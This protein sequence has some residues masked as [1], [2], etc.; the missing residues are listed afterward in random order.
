[1][2][3]FA[4]LLLSAG[5]IFFAGREG[6][7]R[8]RARIDGRSLEGRAAAGKSH[9]AGAWTL[10]RARPVRTARV[11][12]PT[13]SDIEGAGETIR[14]WTS[15]RV[16]TTP[17]ATTRGPKSPAPELLRRGDGLSYSSAGTSAEEACGSSQK[18]G[19]MLR[20]NAQR[21]WNDANLDGRL[22]ARVAVGFEAERGGCHAAATIL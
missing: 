11:N 15:A 14:R 13:R 21:A 1:M 3:F 19:V 5:G 20:H 4:P 7:E 12:A 2:V 22:T 17:F 9:R 18:R 16:Q 10:R 6:V 8:R